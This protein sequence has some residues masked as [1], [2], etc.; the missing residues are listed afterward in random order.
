MVVVVSPGR[1][2]GYNNIKVMMGAARHYRG[3]VR[4]RELGEVNKFL[5]IK[6]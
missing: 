6:R 4:S 2:S 5:S 3:I 1:V